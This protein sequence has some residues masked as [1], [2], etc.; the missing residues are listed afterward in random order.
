MKI[1]RD[2]ARFVD[3]QQLGFVASVNADGTPSL[4]PKGTLRVWKDDRLVFADFRS[5]RTVTNIQARPAVEVNVV[6][7]F[8]R[9]GVRF[10]G[11]ASVVEDRQ[12]IE[13]LRDLFRKS[14]IP[15]ERL[16][17]FVQIAVDRIEPIVSP[18]YDWGQSG[19]DVTEKYM[20]YWYGVAATRRFHEDG[21]RVTRTYLQMMEPSSYAIEWPQGIRVE[22]ATE[23]TVDF[24]RFLYRAVGSAYR[25]R[26]RLKLSDDELQRII[27]HPRVEIFVLYAHGAPAG[28]IEL[29]RRVEDEVEIAYFGLVPE[30]VGRGLGK[31]FLQWGVHTAWQTDPSRVWLHTCSLDHPGAL[32]LYQKVGFVAYRT[33]EYVFE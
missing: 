20:R 9:R 17:R 5:P 6:D 24:Y 21:L 26:D 25:W 16:M 4:S 22:R 3:E 7:V 32:P 31:K 2:I 27:R 10:R 8:M 1:D 23:P 30:Y 19:Y 33:E 18:V 29:D 13:F 15:E 28:Y 14:G 12:E 11:D